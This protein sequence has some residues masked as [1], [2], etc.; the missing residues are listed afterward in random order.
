MPFLSMSATHIRTSGPNRIHGYW[1]TSNIWSH[2]HDKHMG[3]TIISNTA[4]HIIHL[5][6]EPPA[7]SRLTASSQLHEK[8]EDR[9]A[10]VLPPPQ[11]RVA[12]S[13]F[14]GSNLLLYIKWHKS[15][16]NLDFTRSCTF[17]FA[18]LPSS[19]LLPGKDTISLNSKW[20]NFFLSWAALRSELVPITLQGKI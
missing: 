11:N 13:S 3:R 7:R 19:H 2:T 10:T 17:L 5:Y 14:W 18:A 15:A 9:M 6:T 12:E 1:K 4:K 8:A 20:G 16:L